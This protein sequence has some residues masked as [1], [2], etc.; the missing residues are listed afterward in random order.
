M[1]HPNDADRNGRCRVCGDKLS[2]PFTRRG[3]S[4]VFR[5]HLTNKTCDETKG[6]GEP[7]SGR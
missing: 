5:R 2:V 7:V 1:A 4:K 6:R 3:C